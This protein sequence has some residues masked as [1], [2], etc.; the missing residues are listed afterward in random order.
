ML[1]AIRISNSAIFVVEQK[2]NLFFRNI[3]A[4]KS[5]LTCSCLKNVLTLKIAHRIDCPWPKKV[6]VNMIE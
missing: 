4:L 1:S 2:W 6:F 3:F 5:W